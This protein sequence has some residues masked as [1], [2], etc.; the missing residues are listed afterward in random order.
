MLTNDMNLRKCK[1]CGGYFCVKYTSNQECCNRIY[2]AVSTYSEYTSRQTYKDKLFEY[3]IS[4]EYTKAYNKLYARIRRKKLPP[5][6][7]LKEELLKLREE[8]M[9][10]YE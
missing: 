4:S 8:Y 6:T 5:D 9:K 10:L 2:S 7:P 3:A 1:N